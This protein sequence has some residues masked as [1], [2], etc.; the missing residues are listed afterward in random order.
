MLEVAAL[1]GHV[2]GEMNLDTTHFTCPRL[3]HLSPG[4]TSVVC[5]RPS[6]GPA[7]GWKG[8]E[9]RP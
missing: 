9:G 4:L 3:V 8:K 1:V 2:L 7:L 6:T 5:I